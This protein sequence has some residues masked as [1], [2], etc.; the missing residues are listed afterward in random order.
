[1]PT[2]R[3]IHSFFS[4]LLGRRP[5]PKPKKERV[6]LRITSN[7][8]YADAE[9]PRIAGLRDFKGYKSAL[10]LM[11]DAVRLRADQ[12]FLEPAQET[13]NVSFRIDGMKE[14]VAG[15]SRS[16][17]DAVIGIF[18]EL[19]YL[20][21]EE[22]RKPQEGR[23]SARVD[24]GRTMEFRVTSSGTTAGEK[25]TVRLFDQE[26]GLL[27]LPELGM[28]QNVREAIHDLVRR[29]QGLL[30]VCGPPDS[31][32]TTTLNACLAEID[33]YRMNIVALDTVACVR[34]P[35]VTYREINPKEGRTV[36][37]ELPA[38]L[39]EGM[40]V[41]CISEA[42]DSETANLACKSAKDG[43]MVLAAL[44]AGDTVTGLGTLL[45][46]GVKPSLLRGTLMAVL[47]QRLVRVLCRRC[48]VR[49]KPDPDMLR[50]ANLP[51]DQIKRFYRPPEPPLIEG[52]DEPPVCE[53]CG[54]GGYYGRMGVFELLIINERVREMI[55]D[56]MDLYT[57]K[58]E[59]VK[60]GMKRLQEEGMR[61][62]IAGKTSIQ[63][64]IRVCN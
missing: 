2:A 35:N 46:L 33:R 22:K 62:V 36:A 43:K 45:D 63:E 47:A 14:A 56:D 37:A 60:H 41:L 18:K 26:R 64:I 19:A 34:V 29:R 24:E 7:G 12:V 49:Y 9:D 28:T 13:T 53:H 4:R 42:G 8:E 58:Q 61:L 10:S 11:S 27:M 52:T 54:G 25:L 17:G 3:R 59:A 1:V 21:R 57:I 40:D 30:I 39:R 31:G 23:I 44:E 48:R 6:R 38:V 32:K 16:M 50:K 5:A 15:F 20:N 55:R 51:A